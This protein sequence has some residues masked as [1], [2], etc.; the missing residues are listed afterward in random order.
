MAKQEV[1]RVTRNGKPGFQY[2]TD[3]DVFLY[4]AGDK[5]SRNDAKAKAFKQAGRDKAKRRSRSEGRKSGSS[6]R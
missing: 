3:G 2:G 4:K 5:R 1:H 6:R